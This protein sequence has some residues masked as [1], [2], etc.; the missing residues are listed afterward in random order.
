MLETINNLVDNAQLSINEIDRRIA[1]LEVES[2]QLPGKQQQ[3]I[4]YQRNFDFTDDTYKYLMHRRAEAQILRASNTPDNE[5]LD[6]ARLDRTGRISP[7]T[8][9][10]YLIA[11]IIG[12]LIPALFL[13]LKN[14]FKSTIS[15]RS[16]VEKLTRYPIIGQVAQTN[17]KDPLLVVNNP[18]SPVSAWP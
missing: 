15:D 16:E 7:R 5:I 4:N 17:S 1:T 18:K 14:Y 3:L 11:V 8:S 2:R 10:N 9:M 6:E 12:L 13:F